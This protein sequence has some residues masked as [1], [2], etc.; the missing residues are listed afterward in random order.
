[1]LDLCAAPGGKATELGARLEVESRGTCGNPFTRQN[2]EQ[3]ISSGDRDK[4]LLV[5]ND[6]S[7]SRALGL[8]KNIELMGITNSLVVSE[9]PEKLANHLP[10]YFDKILIDA[11]CSGEGMFRKEPRMIKDWEEKGPE[12]YSKIQKE[13]ILQGSRMLQPGGMLLYST[14][15]FD[16]R[17]N[18]QVVD[19][20]LSNCPEFE[21]INLNVYEGFSPGL[22]E[23]TEINN[24][25]LKKTIRLYPHRLKGEGHYIALMRKRDQGEIDVVERKGSN[26]EDEEY[27]GREEGGL[28]ESDVEKK[29][30][31][32][33]IPQELVDFLSLINRVIDMEGLFIKEDKSGHGSVYLL[34]AGSPPLA[35]LR[36]LRTGLHLGELKKRRFEPS[37]A[38]A[39]SLKKEVFDLT[40]DFQVDDSRV[41]KYLKGETLDVTDLTNK[42]EKGWA[43]ICVC[44]Y[45]LGFGK[46]ANQVLKNKYKTGWRMM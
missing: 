22:P 44:G 29:G 7:Y 37:Q 8:L 12:Y 24:E 13:I 28:K 9:E 25:E 11:P 26:V 6:I 30:R 10:E 16:P 39:M 33:M 18:E 15:T 3:S 41:L 42:N 23:V 43:L 1:V 4:G 35:G 34:P 36:F 14:C 20:L 38:L 32:S 2:L 31:V 19:Y 45:P 21:L 40:I 46:L 17:E 5:A 27:V